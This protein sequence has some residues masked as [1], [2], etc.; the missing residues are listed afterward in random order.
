MANELQS[1]ELC[2]VSVN[3]NKDVMKWQQKLSTQSWNKITH[4]WLDRTKTDILSRSFSIP[5]YVI[6]DQSGVVQHT[7]N[8]WD[9]KEKLNTLLATKH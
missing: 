8:H 1:D 7:T 4:G 2:F 3:V 6:V 5:L 9:V